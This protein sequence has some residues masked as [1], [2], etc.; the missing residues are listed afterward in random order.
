MLH[1]TQ[2]FVI[3]VTVQA[4]SGKE[5]ENSTQRNGSSVLT[6][7]VEDRLILL[8]KRGY[9]VVKEIVDNIWVNKVEEVIIDIYPVKRRLFGCYWRI[10]SILPN[11]RDQWANERN[12]VPD[13]TYHL[14]VPIRNTKGRSWSRLWRRHT[15][16]WA[17]LEE[18]FRHLHKRCT[19][20]YNEKCHITAT[21]TSEGPGHRKEN[22]K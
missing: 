17:Y 4:L 19:V 8:L 13:G 14:S 10:S 15:S 18:A 11:L 9:D 22:A 7:L 12:E 1:P 20:I 6:Q 16:F 2:V 3:C 5:V 21:K